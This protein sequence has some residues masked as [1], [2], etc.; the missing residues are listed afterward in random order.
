MWLG[1][2]VENDIVF[3]KPSRRPT[4]RMNLTRNHI[5]GCYILHLKGEREKQM[6]SSLKKNSYFLQTL[7]SNITSLD[8]NKFNHIIRAYSERRNK[9]LYKLFKDKIKETNESLS[10]NPK[11]LEEGLEEFCPSFSSWLHMVQ[12]FLVPCQETFHL[13]ALEK[14][15]TNIL[16]SSSITHG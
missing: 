13:I 6:L 7:S 16:T 15:I 14:P 11:V 10:E 3:E 2:F 8:R 5:H 1:K 12:Q 4:I 9:V